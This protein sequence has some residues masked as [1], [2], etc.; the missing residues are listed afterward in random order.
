MAWMSSIQHQLVIEWS[1]DKAKQGLESVS[2][3]KLFL[4]ALYVKGLQ[5][6]SLMGQG[7]GSH[8]KL[9]VR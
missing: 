1:T 5:A 6:A 9:T 2:Q 8:S 7:V 4:L 3:V